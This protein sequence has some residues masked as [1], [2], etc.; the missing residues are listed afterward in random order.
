VLASGSFWRKELLSWL[1]VPFEVEVSDFD[2]ESVEIG[3]PG[4]LVVALA[5]AKAEKVARQLKSGLVI[6]ADTII[7]VDGNVV[8][9]PK[10]VEHAREILNQLNGCSHEVYT[11][12]VVIEVETGKK[13]IESQKS[14]VWFKDLSD[15]KLEKY[16]GSKEW[17]GKAGAYQLIGKAKELVADVEGSVTGVVGLPLRKVAELLKK[18]GVEI[19]VDVGKVIKEKTG[20]ES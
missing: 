1:R 13:L 14:V 10:D 9:K 20:F 6:G 8:G 12:V 19:L 2:E 17:V 3:E 4:Q 11:G 5:L 7:V 15:K 16:L 18:F